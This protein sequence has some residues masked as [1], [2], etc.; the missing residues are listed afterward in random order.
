MMKKYAAFLL[1]LV[2]LFS[3]SA[4]KKQE[5]ENDT[6][7]AITVNLDETKKAEAK[8]KTGENDVIKINI[9]LAIIEEEYQNDLD[10]Y[11]EKYG[12]I[13]AKLGANDTVTLKLSGQSHSLLLSRMGMTVMKEIGSILDSGDYPYFKNIG[14]Y[15][16]DFSYMVLL[17]DGEEYEDD[18]TSNFLPY[19]VSECCMYYQLYTTRTSYECEIIIADEK[20]NEIIYQNTYDLND[21]TK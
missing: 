17:V 7:T 10:A 16:D 18:K 12:Y 14:T 8:E 20:T 15:N 2:L 21:F 11:V 1:C 19:V 3:L 9:P 4:C 13:S 6:G 5:Q